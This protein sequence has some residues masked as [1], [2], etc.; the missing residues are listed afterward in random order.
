VGG[1]RDWRRFRPDF[2]RSAAGGS[3]GGIFPFNFHPATVFLGDSGALTIGFVPGCP[4][5]RWTAHSDNFASVLAPPPVLSVPLLDV[6]ASVV[7]RTLKRQ[8]ISSADRA[9]VPRSGGIFHG[10]A[11]ETRILDLP[12][13][14]CPRGET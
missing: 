7:R 12:A 5:V 11:T 3:A 2:H 1:G 8:P 9:A 10:G 6:S 13:R 14:I 4:A